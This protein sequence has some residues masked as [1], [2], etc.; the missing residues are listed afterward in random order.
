MT[1]SL[2]ITIIAISLITSFLVTRYMPS[3]INVYRRIINKIKRKLYRP[4]HQC[5]SLNDIQFIV[6]K[7]VEKQLKNI[8]ND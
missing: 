8:I 5:L 4:K 1:T 3:L 7:E 6:E 2:Y